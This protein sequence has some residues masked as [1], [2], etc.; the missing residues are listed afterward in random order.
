MFYFF[1]NALLIL[2][3]LAWFQEK[4]NLLLKLLY[5]NLYKI[6]KAKKI[7]IEKKKKR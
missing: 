6:K 5:L 2:M 4:I 3:I 7:K 1:H